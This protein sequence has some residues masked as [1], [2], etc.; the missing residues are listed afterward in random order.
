[1]TLLN[2]LHQLPTMDL[3]RTFCRLLISLH[4]QRII[5]IFPFPPEWTMKHNMV[6]PSSLNSIFTA[7]LSLLYA[8]SFYSEITCGRARN[9]KA[10]KYTPYKIA[11][12][13]RSSMA[14]SFPTEQ[15][16]GQRR[17]GNFE[18]RLRSD[19]SSLL[20]IVAFWIELGK[21]QSC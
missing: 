11:Q 2:L 21:F 10:R 1:M 6:L 5:N 19:N 18:T 12:N 3:A 7:V 20:G 17:S 16:K 13:N 15:S 14:L 9:K 8:F 4:D